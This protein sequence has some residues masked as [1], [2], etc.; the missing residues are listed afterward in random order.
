MSVAT[1]D[2][3]KMP[4][5]GTP[6]NSGYPRISSTFIDD[7][8][9]IADRVLAN[10][11]AMIHTM[12]LEKKIEQ[13]YSSRKEY[14]EIVRD[15]ISQLDEFI[16]LLINAFGPH[17]NDDSIGVLGRAQKSRRTLAD[18]SN[19]IF[20]RWNTPDEFD[21]LLLDETAISPAVFDEFAKRFPPPQSWYD[22]TDNPF[23]PDPAEIES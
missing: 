9:A 5:L 19:R 23:E 13:L 4:T 18:F 7:H 14:E 10:W 22:E 17:Y 6:A 1:L 12:I 11:K 3:Y 15:W 8:L 21:D 16:N 20:Q 2:S